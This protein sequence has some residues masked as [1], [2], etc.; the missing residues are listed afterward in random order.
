MKTILPLLFFVTFIFSTSSAQITLSGDDYFPVVGDTLV[1]A[2]ATAATGVMIT[3]PGGD[4]SWDFSALES[5][6][7]STRI[8]QPVSDAPN[9]DAFPGANAYI[10]QQV[11]GNGFYRSNSESFSIIG[12]EGEDPLG[13]GIEVET[14]FTPPYVERWGSLEFF[15]IN[16]LNSALTITVATDDIPGNI[17][18]DLPVSPDS[19]RVRVVIDRTDLVDGWGAMTI[20]GGTYDVLREKRTEIRDIRLDAKVSILPWVDVTD[21]A[22]DALPIDALGIDTTV[23]YQFWSNEAKEPIVTINTNVNEDAITS[24]EYK[25]NDVVNPVFNLPKSPEVSVFPNPAINQAKIQFFDMEE[26]NYQLD[27][28]NLTGRSVM[29]EKYHITGNTTKILQLSHLSKGMYIYLLS[30][31]TGKR[32]ATRRLIV[33]KP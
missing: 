28:F 4:Q 21:I 18:D 1:T 32:I 10:A 6:F 19:I 17:F 9:P 11:A 29:T 16:S 31:E 27:I 15:D 20:P 7:M 14:P 12:F 3:A 25:Y 8:I 23:T 33:A 24:V 13:Q 22:I 2:T 26:G 5:A 30:D